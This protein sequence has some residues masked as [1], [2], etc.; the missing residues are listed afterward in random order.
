MAEQELNQKQLAIL[1]SLLPPGE[2]W[3][4]DPEAYLTKQ[5]EGEAGE[6]AEAEERSLDLRAEMT[7][8]S[9]LELLTE[10]EAEYGLPGKCS[11]A[12]E[13]LEMRRQAILNLRG[14]PGG[15]HTGRY[16]EIAQRLGYEGITFTELRPSVAGVMRSGDM[17][18]GQDLAHVFKV[19]APATAISY[20]RAGTGQAGDRLGYFGDERLECAINRARAAHT[21][22]VFSYGE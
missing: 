15:H 5:L 8:F 4:R 19:N 2:A 14:D 10:W 7:P 21:L 22:A 12:E 20:L 11:M 1:Q 9:V 18:L 3:P 13:N 16:A 6:L 17:V